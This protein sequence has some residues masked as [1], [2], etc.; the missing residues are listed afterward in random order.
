MMEV[1][2][3][4]AWPL[5]LSLDFAGNFQH[6]GYGKI[7]KFYQYPKSRCEPQTL[8]GSLLGQPGRLQEGD[9]GFSATRLLVSASLFLQFV[10]YR[11]DERRW[12][13]SA[14]GSQAKK[15]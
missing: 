12:S 1:K 11:G 3:Q 7:Q 2:E 15:K 4:G 6:V 10:R 5:L 8:L 14:H 13:G 9:D